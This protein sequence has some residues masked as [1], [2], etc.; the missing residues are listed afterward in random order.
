MDDDSRRLES[1]RREINGIDCDIAELFVHRMRACAEVA[2]FKMEHGLP[3]T[4]AVREAE[5]IRRNSELVEDDVLRDYFVE[6]ERDI[7]NISKKYQERLTK[8]LKVAYCGIPGAFASIAAS[9]M[10]PN[11]RTI[12]YSDFFKAYKACED[13]DC[14]I[15]VLPVENSFA[16][17]VSAVTDLMFSGNLYINQIIELEA[18]QNLLGV[19][20]ASLDT[21]KEV[22]SHPQALS[23]CDEYIE[24]KGYVKHE[25]PNTA[26]SA[27]YVAE[28]NDP[29]VAAI[30]S[31]ECA[32]IYSLKIL[33]RHINTSST[34]TTRFAAFSRSLNLSSGKRRMDSH[35]ILMF[36]VKNEAGSLAKTLNIIGSHGFNMCSLRS[37][38]MKD[39]M[40]N[41]YFYIEL[42]GNINTLD[43]RSMMQELGTLCERL[44]LVASF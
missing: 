4:D 26:V 2:R 40:W 22:I 28:R 30:A 21:V 17:E 23:Q 15:A 41:Y 1:I 14:D 39:L 31:E 29:S 24:S 35:F 10:F 16:G 36:T 19:D 32:S 11:S 20:G 3:I 9:R 13:G 44:K 37:R 12:P 5:V 6:F 42:D 38:P 8:G 33:E 27:K 43:G 34:N 18:V 25:Y 7:I